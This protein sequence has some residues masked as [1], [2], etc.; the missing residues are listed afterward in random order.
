MKEVQDNIVDVSVAGF[1]W[2][3]ERSEAVDFTQGIFPSTVAAII[4]K[5]SRHDASL[6][7]F[8]L[9]KIYRVQ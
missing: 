7:Y 6:R 5:P 8:F 2:N 9:G 3:M 1:V 4:R